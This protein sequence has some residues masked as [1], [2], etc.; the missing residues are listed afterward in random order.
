MLAT[1]GLILF[2]EFVPSPDARYKVGWV[3]VGITGAIL[4]LN[5]SVMVFTGVK[6]ALL[7]CKLKKQ[8]YDN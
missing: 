6:G 7:K 8:R 1:Y 4:S 5:I 3:I 2:T